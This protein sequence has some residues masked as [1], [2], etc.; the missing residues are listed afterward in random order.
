MLGVKGISAFTQMGYD[1][2][3]SYRDTPGIQ[4]GKTERSLE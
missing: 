3:D 4:F 1:L 2:S